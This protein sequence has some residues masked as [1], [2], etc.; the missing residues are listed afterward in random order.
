MQHYEKA[1][2]FANFSLIVEFRFTSASNIKKTINS[3][4]RVHLTFKR[5]ITF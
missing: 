4:S 2:T 1:K 5:N 3:N